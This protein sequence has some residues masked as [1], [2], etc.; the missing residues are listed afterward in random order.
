MN[1][2]LNLRTLLEASKYGLKTYIFYTVNNNDFNVNLIL[3][4]ISDAK[5]REEIFEIVLNYGIDDLAN[6]DFYEKYGHM[7]RTELRDRREEWLRMVNIEL[8]ENISEEWHERI[9]ECISNGSR[10]ANYEKL[11]SNSRAFLNM[12]YGDSVSLNDE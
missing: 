1:K 11:V 9:E 6:P 2:N 12:F 10:Y 8:L 3:S 5:S 4:N 7:E